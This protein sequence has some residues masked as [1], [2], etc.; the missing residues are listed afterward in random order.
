MVSVW[1]N[2]HTYQNKTYKHNKPRKDFIGNGQIEQNKLK[3]RYAQ[4]GQYFLDETSKKNEQ[5]EYN[6]ENE[7]KA[8]QL[9]VQSYTQKGECL[10][11]E[12]KKYKECEISSEYKICPKCKR[13]YI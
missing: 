7:Q 9:M 3:E 13:I 6:L 11:P 4:N 8:N 12:C 10:C 5:V 1:R 2:F